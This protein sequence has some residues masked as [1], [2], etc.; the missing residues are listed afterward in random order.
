MFVTAILAAVA[1]PTFLTVK[2]AA[3]GNTWFKSGVPGWPKVNSSGLNF[4]RGAV[5]QAWEVQGAELQR[6]GPLLGGGKGQLTTAG[7]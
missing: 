7:R 1:I 5:V 6:A 3:S 4:S 2:E